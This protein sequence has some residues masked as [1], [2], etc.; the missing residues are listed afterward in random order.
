MT[1]RRTRVA[2]G[3]SVRDKNTD[4]G[5]E[6]YGCERRKRG[7]LGDIPVVLRRPLV[8]LVDCDLGDAW[9]HPGFEAPAGTSVDC[10]CVAA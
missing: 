8:P 1:V 6:H 3:D 5:P 4:G 9:W 7:M 2:T 10:C